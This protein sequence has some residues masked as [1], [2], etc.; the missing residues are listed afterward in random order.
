[1]VILRCM[2]VPGYFIITRVHYAITHLNSYR[3]SAKLICNYKPWNAAKI[4]NKKKR[5]KTLKNIFVLF[6]SSSQKGDILSPNEGVFSFGG[7]IPLYYDDSW[8][9]FKSSIFLDSRFHNLNY[10]EMK[11]IWFQISGFYM[12]QNISI[13]LSN[14]LKFLFCI[15]FFK[16]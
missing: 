11:K 7:C 2:T 16:K 8:I 5:N 10:L 6:F 14:I 3:K 9:I 4:C 13:G 15:K 12:F 1:M